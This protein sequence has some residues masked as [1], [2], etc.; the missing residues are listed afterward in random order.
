[1]AQFLIKY[2][3][4]NGSVEEWHR[5][6]A[7]FIAAIDSDP[8]LGG[9]IT[10]RCMKSRNGT[11]Y[12]HLATTA[13]ESATKAL[14]EREFFKRYTESA[15]LAAGGELEVVPLETIAETRHTS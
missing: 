14:Q 12:Y 9:K 4:T 1:M 6:I 5:E 13:D 11:D 2:R 8:A 10:Y 3:F 7:Q 15:K